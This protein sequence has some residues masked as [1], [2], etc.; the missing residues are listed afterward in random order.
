[1][2]W[3]AGAWLGCRIESFPSQVWF[4]RRYHREK[5]RD[6]HRRK[7]LLRSFKLPHDVQ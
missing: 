4:G 2:T 5:S 7:A 3:F 1:M 6:A